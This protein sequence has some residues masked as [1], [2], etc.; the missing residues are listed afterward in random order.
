MK[1]QDIKVGHTYCNR[2]KGRTQRKVLGEQSPPATH[3][4][5]TP[6]ARMFDYQ[7]A[8]TEMAIA[9]QKYSLFIDW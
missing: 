9:K 6:P 4:G 8:I 3:A 7:R 2:G 5:F 1:E